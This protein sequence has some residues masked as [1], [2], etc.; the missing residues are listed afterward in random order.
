MSAFPTINRN[1]NLGVADWRC[2]S[3]TVQQIPAIFAILVVAIALHATSVGTASA[4]APDIEAENC[5]F[6]VDVDGD[7]KGDNKIPTGDEHFVVQDSLITGSCEFNLQA[8]EMPT[9]RVESDLVDW[10]GIVEV[11]NTS[12][13][14]TDI[15]TVDRE[16]AVLPELHGDLEVKV[17]IVRGHAP[18]SIKTEVIAGRYRTLD[19]EHDVQT[20]RRFR[21]VGIAVISADTVRDRLEHNVQSATEAYLDTRRYLES[22][23]SGTPQWVDSLAYRWLEKGYPRVAND[24]A[25]TSLEEGESRGNGGSFWM[26]GAIITWLLIAL[27]VLASIAYLIWLN[28]RNDQVRR[29]SRS[30]L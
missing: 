21:I 26:W 27:S 18:R 2:V 23:E 12:D 15:F 4:Q 17:V 14:S 3:A 11:F 25:E 30:G 5:E 1:V 6:F 29:P 28:T 22:V 13:R 8:G 10:E 9:L 16:R 24:I 7:L 19:Y 20:P